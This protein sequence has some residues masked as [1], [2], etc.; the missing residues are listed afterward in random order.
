MLCHALTSR[1][2]STASLSSLVADLEARVVE[3]AEDPGRQQHDAEY[4]REELGR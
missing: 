2:P 4:E 3:E 1:T